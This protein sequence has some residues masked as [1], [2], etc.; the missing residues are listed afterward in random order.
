MHRQAVGSRRGKSRQVSLGRFN[1]EV[2]VQGQAG[3]SAGRFNNDRPQ[4]DVGH[5]M[6]VH[7]INVYPVRPTCFT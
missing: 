5:K 6:P 4:R 7:H 3:G 2:N 1:H